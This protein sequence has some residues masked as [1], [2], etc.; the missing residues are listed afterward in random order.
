VTMLGTESA[1]LATWLLLHQ[2]YNLIYKHVERCATK[3]GLSAATA[4]PLLVLKD[5]GHPLPL[6][7][8]ARL[9]VQEAQSITSLIDRLEG[10]GLVRRVPDSRDR[11]VINVALTPNGEAVANQASAALQEALGESFA[12]LSP[13]EQEAFSKRLGALRAHGV[14]VLGLNPALFDGRSAT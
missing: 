3:S 9:L 14:G 10:K 4:M 6:S 12:P 2:T 5:T 11:R 8:L 7:H 1:P 13:R